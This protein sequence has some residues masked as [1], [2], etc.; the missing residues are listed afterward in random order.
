VLFY[1]IVCVYLDLV[2][3]TLFVWTAY[4]CTKIQTRTKE[5]WTGRRRNKTVPCAV[6]QEVKKFAAVYVTVAV[7]LFKQANYLLLSSVRLIQAKTL[8][9][10]SLR[11][12]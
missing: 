2:Y 8:H 5:R 4:Y 1:L 10:I 3:S 12:F 11:P 6:N 7:G 9:P